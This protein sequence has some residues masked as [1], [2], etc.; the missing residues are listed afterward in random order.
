MR[1]WLVLRATASQ[2]PCC[3]TCRLNM[4]LAGAAWAAVTIQSILVVLL[5]GFLLFT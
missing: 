1:R 2:L 5:L 3:V 4:G